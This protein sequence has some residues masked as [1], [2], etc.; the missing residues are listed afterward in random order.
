[1]EAKIYYFD[2]IK[3]ENP[4]YSY[5]KGKKITRVVPLEEPKDSDESEDEV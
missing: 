1:M 2:S 5:P 4:F 3:K